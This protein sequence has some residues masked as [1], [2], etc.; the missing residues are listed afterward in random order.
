MARP[1]SADPAADYKPDRHGDTERGEREN[2]QSLSG[3]PGLDVMA[4]ANRR[5]EASSRRQRRGRLARYR[6]YNRRTAC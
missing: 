6:I 1:D 4:F 2:G 5:V 3:R